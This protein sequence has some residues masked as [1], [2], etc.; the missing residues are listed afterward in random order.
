M[1][2]FHISLFLPLHRINSGT[3][4]IDL[5]NLTFEN[6]RVATGENAM[7]LQGRASLYKQLFQ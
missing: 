3:V 5:G 4:T 7:I 6:N 1:H 2:G